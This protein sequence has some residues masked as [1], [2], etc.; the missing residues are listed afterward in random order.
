MVMLAKIKSNGAQPNGLGIDEATA[1]AVD[2][3]GNL[4]VF[5]SNEAWFLQ[6]A[7]SGPEVMNNG[8]PFTWKADGK[9][10]KVIRIKGGPKGTPAGNLRRWRMTGGQTE[11]WQAVNGTLQ[12]LPVTQ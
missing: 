12:I 3:K 9:A 2:R 7:K 11:Y 5:G 10:V 8:H 1:V 6:A 4:L